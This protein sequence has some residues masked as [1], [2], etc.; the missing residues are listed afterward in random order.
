MRTYSNFFGWQIIFWKYIKI[1]ESEQKGRHK[2]IDAHCPFHVVFKQ[3]LPPIQ[4]PES[5]K[6]FPPQSR[7][8]KKWK[9]NA[10]LFSFPAIP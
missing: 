5:K 2:A 6:N 1:F 7:S 8:V 3:I 4:L 9:T 10:G